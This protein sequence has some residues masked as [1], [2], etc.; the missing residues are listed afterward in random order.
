MH[1]G[2]CVYHGII[3]STNDSNLKIIIGDP[4]K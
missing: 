1:G 3:A 4:T 2:F